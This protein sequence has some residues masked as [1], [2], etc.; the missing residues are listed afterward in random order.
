MQNTIEEKIYSCLERKGNAVDEL[1][2][3]MGNNMLNNED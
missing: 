1:Y 3:E 2:L